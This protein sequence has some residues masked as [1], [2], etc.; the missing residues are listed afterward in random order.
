MRSK[1]FSSEWG[2]GEVLIFEDR[3]CNAVISECGKVN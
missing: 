1:V 2:R 3:R